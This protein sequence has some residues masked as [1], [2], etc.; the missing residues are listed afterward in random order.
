MT[1][2]NALQRVRTIGL[3]EHAWIPLLR[4]RL[5][6]EPPGLIDESLPAF[7]QHERGPRLID[8]GE[9]RLRLMDD[10]GIDMQVLSTT[11]PGTQSL[12][13][14][15]ARTLAR[16]ANDRLSDAVSEHPD[17]FAKLTALTNPKRI[18]V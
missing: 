9:E 6:A 18:C 17:R 10:A 1:E 14:A 2:V 3:E 11:T 5:M 7:N 13:A 15:E 12:P 8:L 4:D 16:E